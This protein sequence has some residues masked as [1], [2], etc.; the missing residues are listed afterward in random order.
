MVFGGNDAQL[1][2][3]EL[4]VPEWRPQHFHALLVLEEG[5]IASPHHC[6]GVTS[7]GCSNQQM[8]TERLESDSVPDLGLLQVDFNAGVNPQLALAQI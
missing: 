8:A 1:R 5:V 7:L 2:I 4:S 6:R 3:H